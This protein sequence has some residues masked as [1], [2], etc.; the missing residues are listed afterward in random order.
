MQNYEK[1]MELIPGMA[2]TVMATLQTGALL[3]VAFLLAHFI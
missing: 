1:T 2:S 3:L